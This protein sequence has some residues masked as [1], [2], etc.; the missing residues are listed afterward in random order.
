MEPCWRSCV[1]RGREFDALRRASQTRDQNTVDSTKARIKGRDTSTFHKYGSGWVSVVGSKSYVAVEN[2]DTIDKLLENLDISDDVEHFK[3][4][5]K[6]ERELME[7]IAVL[8]RKYGVDWN[9]AAVPPTLARS[10]A[11]ER[12]LFLLDKAYRYWHW[13]L[14][15]DELYRNMFPEMYAKIGNTT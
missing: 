7:M 12:T 5:A 2:L 9:T 6:Y 4:S 13:R 10:P 8:Y 14:S 1:E 11:W 3:L 15:L